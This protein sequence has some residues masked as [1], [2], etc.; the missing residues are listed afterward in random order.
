M[1]EPNQFPPRKKFYEENGEWYDTDD[2]FLN[3]PVHDY[4]SMAEHSALLYEAVR[5][6]RASAFRRALALYIGS[7]TSPW[8]LGHEL[9]EELRKAEEDTSRAPTKTH[10][11][12]DAGGGG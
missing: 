8:D 3:G 9:K 5:E 10:G 2:S 6:A 4:L 1:T 7:P 12:G 11:V